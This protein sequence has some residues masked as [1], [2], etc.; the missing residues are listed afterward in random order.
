M[1]QHGPASRLLALFL[2]FCSLISLLWASVPVLA[3]AEGA[4]PT[5]TTEPFRIVIDYGKP[6][7]FTV[8]ELFESLSYNRDEV[9]ITFMGLRRDGV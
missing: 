8:E 9:T 7:E 5:V 2:V 4:S 1:N 3:Q 6:V